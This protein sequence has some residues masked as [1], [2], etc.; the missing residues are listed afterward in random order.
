MIRRLFDVAE[1]YWGPYLATRFTPRAAV[2]LPMIVVA[3]ARPSLSGP[4]WWP[5]VLDVVVAQMTVLTCRIWDDLADRRADCAVEP[6][7][8]ICRTE[9]ASPFVALG[10]T[11]ALPAGILVALTR[12]GQALAGFVSV[13]LGLALWYASR[14]LARGS[15]FVNYHVVLL[16]YPAL[17][18]VIESRWSDG[19]SPKSIAWALVPYLGLCAFEYFDDRRI[20]DNGRLRLC[21]IA[22]AA[23]CAGLLAV[24]LAVG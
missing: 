16:K 15:L 1:H 13:H 22:E 14:Q 21:A 19:L 18:L 3:F 7:R 9:H 24:L 23:G 17:T 6:Q 2:M 11:A 5:I 12:P 4:S 8:V 20:R 10:L